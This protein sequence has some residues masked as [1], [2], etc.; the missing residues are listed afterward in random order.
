MH[1]P[2]QLVWAMEHIS[3]FGGLALAAILRR[4]G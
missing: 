4:R 2:C 1:K 3:L